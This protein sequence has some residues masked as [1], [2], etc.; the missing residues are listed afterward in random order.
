MPRKASSGASGVFEKPPGSGV[1]WIRYRVAGKEKRE[2][3]GLKSL[4]R[5]VLGKRLAEIAEDRF[6]DRKAPVTVA[7]VIADNLERSAGHKDHRHRVEQAAWWTRALGHR[8]VRDVTPG[9]I[10]RILAPLRKT[11]AAATVN[12]RRSF[13]SRVFS[14]AIED[15]LADRNPVLKVKRLKEN[16]IRVRSLTPE[17]ESALARVMEP[18]DMALVRLAMHTGLRRGEQWRLRWSDIGLDGRHLRVQEAKSGEG[19]WVPLNAQARLA[20][21][22]LR[23]SQPKGTERVCPW[24]AAGFVRRRWERALKAAGIEGIRWHDLRH[25]F[26]SRLAISGTPIYTIQRLL[27]HQSIE[28]TMRYAHLMPGHLADAVAVLDS[29]GTPI[30]TKGSD[31]SVS[32][33]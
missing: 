8:Q 2:K 12:R 22:V 29:F 21:D 32:N 24:T 17:E 5:T 11:K 14:Q 15:D 31:G 33:G 4:A 26:A 28:M 3:I 10:E 27:G 19:R 25:T 18:T 6:L 1:Y 13:L 23:A 7:K 9:D 20:L 16:N 30:G